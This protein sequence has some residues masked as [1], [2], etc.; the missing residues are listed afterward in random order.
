MV[1]SPREPIRRQKR[2]LVNSPRHPIWRQERILVNSPRHPIWR[3]EI[4]LVNSPQTPHL[5]T[6]KNISK[7]PQRPHLKTGNDINKRLWRPT[8]LYYIFINIQLVY[9]IML[10]KEPISGLFKKPNY[11]NKILYGTKNSIRMCS[12]VYSRTGRRLMSAFNICSC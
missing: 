5:E 11:G 2:T 10:S 1:N 8:L 3:Q 6:L 12:I 7:L 4:I 9:I